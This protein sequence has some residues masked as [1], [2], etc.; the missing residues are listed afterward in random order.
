VVGNGVSMRIASI[1]K[2]QK[3]T[4]KNDKYVFFFEGVNFVCWPL[5]IICLKWCFLTSTNV[6]IWRGR[7]MCMH[8]PNLLD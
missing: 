6:C 1:Y 5:G 4:Y 3:K 2:G 8:L 7:T